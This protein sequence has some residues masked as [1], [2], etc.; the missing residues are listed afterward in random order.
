MKH[1]LS[2]EKYKQLQDELTFLSKVKRA[3]L[4]ESWRLAVQEGDDRETDALTVALKLI[5]ENEIR[6]QEVFEMLQ[7]SE[8]KKKLSQ[9]SKKAQLGSSLEVRIGQKKMNI[10][11]VDPIEADPLQNKI[12]VE[13][14]LGQALLNQ[15]EGAKLNYPA[16]NGSTVN[17]TLISVSS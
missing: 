10:K 5:S 16:P 15:K 7:N 9:K 4:N 6:I 3:E 2:E 14:P 13:T 17:V 11:L 1:Q 8:I 12:S